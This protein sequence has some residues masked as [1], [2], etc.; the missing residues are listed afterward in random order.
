MGD[1]GGRLPEEVVVMR[2]SVVHVVQIE[3]KP[4]SDKPRVEVVDEA[5]WSASELRSAVLAGAITSGLV[6]AIAGL[7][8]GFY[9]GLREGER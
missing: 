7:G 4:D 8:I 6:C 1:D 3:A 9:L 5:L 2:P